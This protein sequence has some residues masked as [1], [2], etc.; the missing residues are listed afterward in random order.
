VSIH[1][2]PTIADLSDPLS[3]H[4]IK[5]AWLTPV[6]LAWAAIV[7]LSLMIFIAGVP[8]RLSILINASPERLAALQTLGITPSSH[9]AWMVAAEIILMLGFSVT[10]I[11]IYYKKSDIW[12]TTLVS[13]FMVTF[14]T[15]ALSIMNAAQSVHPELSGLVH[16]IKAANWGLL[17][18][19]FYIFPDGYLRPHWAR[20]L[21]IPWILWTLAWFLVPSLPINPTPPGSL[22]S[23]YLFPMYFA[24]LGSG[25]AAQ[26]S[27]YRSYANSHQRQQTKWV[28]YGAAIAVI[29]TFLEEL[30]FALMPELLGDNPAGIAYHMASVMFFVLAALF[31]PISIAMSANMK[32]LWKIDYFIN[33]SLVYGLA[34]AFLAVV[35]VAVFFALQFSFELLD[36][37]NRSG[38]AIAAT[39]LIVSMLFTPTKNRV[40][41]FID[42][43]LYGIQINYQRRPPKKLE[44]FSLESKAIEIGSVV[45]QRP[46]NKGGMGEIYLGEHL[47]RGE[48]V[49]IK[50]LPPQFA[51]KE[52]FQQRFRREAET[53]AALDHPNIVKLYDFG[54]TDG[55]L[56]M[57]M[58]FIPGDSLDA[59]FASYGPLPIDQ[60]QQI[61]KELASA[62][63]YAHSQGVIHRDI[64]P[65]NVLLR[66]SHKGPLHPVL[67][68]FGIAKMIASTTEITQT[69]ILGTFD[70]ISPEQI[71]ASSQVDGRTDIY[72]LGV[73]SF[74]LLTGQLPFQTRS[75]GA[76]LIAHLQQPPPDPRLL[77]PEVTSRQAK[78][79][80]RSL[81][82][83]PQNRFASAAE[84]SQAME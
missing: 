14:G 34:T 73:L 46:L 20:W 21:T 81:E 1:D 64:K 62:I 32:N 15:S 17:M 83:F 28:V 65:S 78:A 84:F 47:G 69:G 23:A 74:Q 41:N 42:R 71:Q 39:T 80:L 51:G 59:H 2:S 4:E 43:E 12:A 58:E 57:V 5:P 22:S 61:L 7:L 3:Y 27:R 35:F 19:V 37:G 53:I 25:V 54:D 26:F 31:V 45:I 36:I 63:D 38:I 49:A 33:R 11:S 68:D 6:R 29:G 82:K 50:I 67:T 40:R 70:F 13:L 72:S 77:R 76:T 30:P 56:F 66:N 75:W 24:W 8:A 52:N 10:G 9:A 55:H 48:Q 60:F 18:P 44:G 16:F 79:I